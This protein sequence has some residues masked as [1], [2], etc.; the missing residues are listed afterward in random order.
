M[1]RP[2]PDVPSVV[3]L[4]GGFTGAVVAHQLAR[5]APGE[6]RITVVEPRE[7]L[8]SGLAYSTAEP[9][10]RINV[11]SS[12]MT[13]VPSDPCHFDRWL[14]RDGV[15][16]EDVGAEL[17]DGRA[18]PARAVFGRY[19]SETLEPYLLSGAIEHVVARA[20]GLACD[21]DRWRVALD[22]G[23][24]LTADAVVLATTHPR[25]DAPP[26]LAP[27]VRDPRVIVDAQRG[28]ALNEV[29]L[30][31][32]VLIVGTGLTMADIVAALDRRGHRGPI[33]A[34]S[35]RGLLSRG[36]PTGPAGEFG[37]FA[38]PPERRASALVL[39]IR[40]AIEAAAAEGRP[41]Q[42]VLD[43]V[44]NQAPA[45]WANLPL[46]ERRR[47]VRRLRPFWDVHRF[48]VAPQVEAAVSRRRSDG[49]L[50]VIRG[51]TQAAEAGERELF[52]TLR[53]AGGAAERR[54][55][56]VVVLATGP[57]HRSLVETDP[58]VS[59][60]YDAGLV[61]PDQ[62]GLG[63]W[64]DD[65]S[66]ALGPD[67]APTPGL[68]IAGPLARGAFGELMGLPEV[69]RHGEAVAKEALLDLLWEDERE[70]A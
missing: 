66:R 33:V 68:F 31:A 13:F 29:D 56:D 42:H 50:V 14:R 64:T 34:T 7:R 26:A 9:A 4:G 16:D 62:V 6:L 63:L 28:D 17:A 43:A 25:P 60:L 48:R 70:V 36:H 3:I 65:R 24:A 23:G 22:G 46:G 30:D 67:G 19:V 11:P 32:R 59:A 18:F 35:R 57:A 38:D 44:R 8:G 27:L 47:I 54:A 61:A 15:L 20:S 10:H 5:R 12:R 41:W 53:P 39:R 51:E 52:V 49:S 45:I 2:G 37:V 40:R 21:G 55:F 69:A 58:L 1:S